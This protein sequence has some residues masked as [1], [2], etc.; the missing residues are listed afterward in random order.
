MILKVRGWIFLIF[1]LMCVVSDYMIRLV[2][3]KFRGHC[4]VIGTVTRLCLL[5]GHLLSKRC[6]IL[7]VITATVS[8]Y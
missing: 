4:S 6:H 7:V 2:K 3:Y 8:S 5:C 1:Y